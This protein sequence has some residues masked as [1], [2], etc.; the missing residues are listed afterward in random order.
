MPAATSRASTTW[1]PTSKWP[2]WKNRKSRSSPIWPGTI[3]V[4]DAATSNYHI[5]E[6]AYGSVE[7]AIRYVQRLVD[8]GADEILF[9]VQMGTI[10]MSDDGNHPQHRQVFDPA[11]QGQAG[12]SSGII[13]TT[14]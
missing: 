7:Q 8:A 12:R 1:M 13:E 6:D 5:E 2:Q 10:R 9:L 4:T 11:F 3:P 14:V